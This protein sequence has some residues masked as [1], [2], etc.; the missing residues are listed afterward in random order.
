VSVEKRNP[1]LGLD[2]TFARQDIAKCAQ[3]F[4]CGNNNN[5]PRTCGARPERFTEGKKQ[6]P[7]AA[8]ERRFAFCACNTLLLVAAPS[9]AD[10]YPWRCGSAL[11]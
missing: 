3:C 9:Q 7:A 8:M 5:A 10:L 2:A 4:R 11:G 1:H 6:E